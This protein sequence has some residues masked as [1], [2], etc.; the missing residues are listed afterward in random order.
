MAENPDGP[1]VARCAPMED[2]KHPDPI[3]HVREFQPQ[4]RFSWLAQ[5]AIPPTHHLRRCR[6]RSRWWCGL[7]RSRLRTR[8]GGRRPIQRQA[9]R[10]AR[11]TH[12][13][14]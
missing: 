6:S 8:N 12:K 3:A 10:H 7:R 9:A 5:P 1:A 2:E 4:S 13:E 11:S 14:P